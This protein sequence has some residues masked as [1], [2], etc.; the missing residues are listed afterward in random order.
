MASLGVK[1]LM[2]VSGVVDIVHND[3]EM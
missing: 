3:D 1:G 2:T